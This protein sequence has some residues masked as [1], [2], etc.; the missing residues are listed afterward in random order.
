MSKAYDRIRTL[1]DAAGED[2]D[3]MF[4]LM[5]DI[6]NIYIEE[7][8]P[9][10]CVLQYSAAAQYLGKSWFWGWDGK[11][12]RHMAFVLLAGA[13]GRGNEDVL[14]E[15]GLCH[16]LGYSTPDGS[17][18]KDKAL[19][20]WKKGMENGDEDC[21]DYYNR[22]KDDVGEKFV[23]LAGADDS[24]C[25]V[26]ADVSDWDSL[27]GLIEAERLDNMRCEKFRS[28]SAELKL[29]GA[30]LGNLDRDGFRKD[31]LEPNWH[32]SQWYDGTAD[33]VGDMIICMEDSDYN[34]FSFS[35]KEEAQKVI[36]ALCK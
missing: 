26:Q 6:V 3:D 24:F 36:D 7:D 27:P 5:N 35:T 33:L 2:P 16:Y 32:A 14:A 10:D 4:G 23:I 18:E 15:L 19:E 29:P 34:P 21:A 13:Y 12:N 1:L 11:Q 8:R 31:W 17:A 30:L 25:I 20:L 28:I 9:E 22:Y